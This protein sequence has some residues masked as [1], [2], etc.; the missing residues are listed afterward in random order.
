MSFRRHFGFLRDHLLAI[1]APLDRD[2]SDLDHVTSQLSDDFL[3]QLEHPETIDRIFETVNQ[4]LMWVKP[5]GS[6][7][8]KKM[9]ESR[10]V[11]GHCS[12][13][14]EME[15]EKEDT[16]Q[17]SSENKVCSCVVIS[18]RGCLKNK[19]GAVVCENSAV[20]GLSFTTIPK[21]K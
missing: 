3:N 21:P 19:D 7:R 11:E 14:E 15:E 10:G 6:G 18:E 9:V 13:G 4:C 2:S 17:A 20:K 5:G 8:G 16:Q 1:V 12:D